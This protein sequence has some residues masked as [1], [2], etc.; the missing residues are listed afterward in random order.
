MVE[1]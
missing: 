1:P